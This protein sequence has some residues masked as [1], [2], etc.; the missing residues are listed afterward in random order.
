MLR[1]DCQIAEVL[2]EGVDED[3]VPKAG[4][5]IQSKD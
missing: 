2:G 5:A 3:E 1:L 4:V